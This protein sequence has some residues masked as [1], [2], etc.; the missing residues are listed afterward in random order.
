MFSVQAGDKIDPE[1]I[2]ARAAFRPDMID[3]YTE[4]PANFQ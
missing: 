1:G 3:V 4:L 2:V